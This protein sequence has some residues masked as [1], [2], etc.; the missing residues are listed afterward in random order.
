MATEKK[1]KKVRQVRTLD[2]AGLTAFGER[3]VLGEGRALFLSCKAGHTYIG[4]IERAY[5]DLLQGA[6]EAEPDDGTLLEAALAAHSGLGRFIWYGLA[7]VAAAPQFDSPVRRAAEKVQAVIGKR[8]P[9]LT[10]KAALRVERAAVVRR[11]VARLPAEVA[12]LPPAPGGEAFGTCIA[13]WCD[14]GR[15]FSNGLVSA[16]VAEGQPVEAPDSTGTKVNRLNGLITRARA[17]LRD[18]VAYDLTLPRT[19]EAEVFGLY[20][21]LLEVH[22]AEVAAQARRTAQPAAAPPPAAPVPAASPA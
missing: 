10:A 5:T 1:A 22:R 17:A 11:E 12:A 6:P 14:Q 3:L 2:K 8:P 19:L 9:S 7:A 18:E 20:D 15:A 21:T 13:R 16:R 4:P